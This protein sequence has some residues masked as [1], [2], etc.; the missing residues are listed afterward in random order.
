MESKKERFKRL[1][2]AR[3]NQVL[4]KLKVLGNCANRQTYDYSVEEINSIFSAIEK[5]AKEVK[6]KFY[7]E[8]VERFKL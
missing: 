5:K 1:A 8:G 3:T 4:H 6:S 7:F 2:S